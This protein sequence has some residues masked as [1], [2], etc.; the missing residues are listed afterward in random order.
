MGKTQLG[1]GASIYP[2][3]S[4]GKDADE[5]EGLFDSGVDEVRDAGIRNV[6]ISFHVDDEHYVDLLRHQ[7]KD[8]QFGLRFRDY[9]VKEPF[10]ERWKT[11]C[12]ERIAQ[13][14]ALVCMIGS[15]TANRKAV[16]WEIREAHRQGKKVIGVR[17]QRNANHPIPQALIDTDAEIVDWNLAR[18][19]KKLEK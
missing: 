11:Q 15:E 13:T 6:F 8:N 9:S 19:S 16:D 18:I 14:S 4:G 10:D 3:S 12:K 2:G 5:A 17:V 1:G 7:A